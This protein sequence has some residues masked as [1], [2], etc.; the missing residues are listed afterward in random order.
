MKRSL[1]FFLLLAASLMGCR[2][3]YEQTP[4]LAATAW[5]PTHTVT[6]TFTPAITPT[7]YPT[8]NLT[9]HPLVWFAPLPPL[10]ENEGRPFTG[11]E[12]FIDLFETN[13][14]WTQAAYRIQVF[15]LYGEWVGDDPWT[16]HASDLQLRQVISDLNRRGIALAMEA[17]PLQAT[18]VCG[19]GIE[20][21]AGGVRIGI[22][23]AQ[24][25]KATGGTLSYIALD[26]PFAFA[27]LYE[28]PNACQWS[29]ERVAKE[30]GAYI[31]GVRTVFP[32]LLVGDTEPLWMDVDVESYKEWL[33]TFRSVNGYDLAF[34]HLDVDFRRADWPQAALKL[35]AFARGQ[36]IDFGIIYLG[37]WNAQTDEEWLVSAGERVKTYEIVA[38]GQPDHILFQSWHDHPDRTLPETEP[39]TFTW[40]INAYFNNKAALGVRTEGLGANLAYKKPITASRSNQAQPQGAVDGEPD[41]YWGAGDFAP[42]WVQIDLGAPYT[43]TG[44]RLLIGQSPAGETVHRIRVK[45]ANVEDAFQVVHTFRG[46][47]L[48]AQWLTV[49]FPEPLD[50]IRYVRVETIISPSWV[51]WKEVEVIA[52]E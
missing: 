31:Q 5:A 20:G 19:Q 41:T 3:S 37:N 30:V 35:E 24:R 23:D 13:A 18:S 6:S 29:A 12:D 40:F 4:T 43:I 33:A 17:G 16:V 22:R 1:F 32:N 10:A 27:S 34:F 52:G 39:Y 44:V 47:T 7:P 8:P 36:G 42:Q 21:F 2:P 50:A 49:T 11:S 14:A 9:Q 25:I 15:K 48:D 26:E 38:G 51:A 28:G 46:V 45:G